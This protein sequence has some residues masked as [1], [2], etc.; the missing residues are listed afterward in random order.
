MAT[1]PLDPLRQGMADFG[2]DLWYQTLRSLLKDPVSQAIGGIEV[3]GLE[4]LPEAGPALLVGNHRTMS[5]PFL[6][7]AVVPRRIH[8]V[9]AAFMGKLPFTRQLAASTGNIVLPVGKG[10]KSQVLMR[11]ARRLLKRNR[12]VGVF[13]EGMDNFMN[14]SPPG[15]VGPF[16]S[17]FARL[18]AALNMPELPILPVALTGEEERV[19]LQFPAAL[20]KMAD[21]HIPTSN[22]G[23]IVAPIY[24]KARIA[25]GEPIYFL[26]LAGLSPEAREAEIPRIVRTVR[27]EVVRLA[28]APTRRGAPGSGPLLDETDSL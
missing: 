4:N 13:P 1:R 27:D 14:G 10:G 20:L 15:T 3:A 5:D 25:I 12:L 16:H 24:R 11:K 9:V 18:I 23:Q 22:D 17:T 21:P 19:L 7:G 28:H 26:E 6:L 2:Q 8:F